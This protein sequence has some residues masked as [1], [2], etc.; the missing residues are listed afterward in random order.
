ML[1]EENCP[2][3]NLDKDKEQNIVFE[4]ETCYFIQHNKE[5]EILEGCGLIVPKKH[6]SNTFDLT[7]DEWK[8]TYEL[9]HRAKEY[10]DNKYSPDG[11]TLGWNVGKVSNQHIFHSHFHIIP[12]YNDEPLSG[13][14]IRY[15]LKQ[16]KNKR[17]NK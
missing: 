6:R 14:G 3:C 11:Y 15:W 5:Q 9:L 10:L 2:F 1:Y 8:D 17:K 4:N 16:P 13:K 7:K 12:R